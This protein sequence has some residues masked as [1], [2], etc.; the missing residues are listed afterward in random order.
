M[1]EPSDASQVLHPSSKGHALADSD[2]QDA[3]FDAKRREYEAMLRSVGL[4]KGW[5]VLDAGSGNGSYLPLI[6]EEVG[7]TG[8]ITALDIAPENIAVI[9]Q[10]IPPGPSIVQLRPSLAISCQS[11]FP[12][13][14]LT[15]SGAPTR[16]ST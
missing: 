16:F 8:H 4:R 5:R 10:R 7:P 1:A 2:W 9:E 15:P 3:H 13:D 6:A 12:A 11:R 14:L